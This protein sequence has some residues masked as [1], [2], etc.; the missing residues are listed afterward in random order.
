M[1]IQQAD[2]RPDIVPEEKLDR[3]SIL[4]IGVLVIAAFVMILNETIMS[5][6]LPRLMDDLDITASTAQWLTTGFLLTM[7]VVIPVT[8]YLFQRF[9]LRQV[10]IAAMGIF[11]AGTLLAALAPGFEVLLA[12]RVTQAGGTAIMLP[13]LMTTVLRVVPANRRGS[14]MGVISI[15]IAVAP[16]IGPTVSGIVLNALDWRWMFWIVL[17]IALVSFAIGVALVKNVT[18]PVAVPLDL[19]SV[20]L[21]VF[22]FG[23]I[24]YG[25]SS[26][27]HS[28]EGS[29]V[30]V[31]IP[32]GVGVVA[33]IVFVRRQI[34]RQSAGR[35]LLDLRP[36]S[37]PTFSIG[38]GMLA[39]SMMALFG[40]LI[41]L[42]LYLQNIRGLDTLTTGLMLLP[43]GLVMG[44]LSPF[45]GRIFDRTGPRVLVIPGAVVVSSALWLMTLLD[46]ES[47]LP[48]VVAVHTLLMAG[49]ATVMTPLMTSS[50][51][52][53]P[54]EL[55]SHGSAIFS[56]IQQLAGAAGT[57]LFITVMSSTA[58]S[59]A[60]DGATE[61]SASQSGIHTAFL[62]GGV[63]SLVA[64][65]ASFF[66]R[67]PKAGTLTSA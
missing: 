60:A 65:A 23:G 36:F 11:S 61:L 39:I 54:S 8:G 48:M 32:L 45:V 30:P 17:P 47:A 24:V 2:D 59:R 26:I 42:P 33:L 37:T 55:Y 50:L 28:A 1:Q 12:G 25:L 16:A 58:A 4:L 18:S 62:Y 14:M 34:S 43:G 35:A 57:A 56:T 21:S 53:L 66:I 7:A 38:L 31:W 10:F 63:V 46:A 44:F 19:V 41:L 40:A 29:A 9:T 51:G 64:V 52:S 13:L 22:A 49:L 67:T 6:A 20:V 3:G 15:V 5:V 27:G